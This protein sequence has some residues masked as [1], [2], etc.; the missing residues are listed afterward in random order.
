VC[1]SRCVRHAPAGRGRR[2]GAPSTREIARARPRPDDR[3]EGDGPSYAG[4]RPRRTRRLGTPDAPSAD[5]PSDLLFDH[6]Y[7]RALID[8]GYQDAAARI[9]EIE[10]FLR[11]GDAAIAA[12][13]VFGGVG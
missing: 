1:T 3:R 7:T 8:A 5:L 10:D 11:G 9:D 13:P 6:G 12:E 4:R 2:S